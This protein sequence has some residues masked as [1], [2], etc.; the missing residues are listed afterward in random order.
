MVLKNV[1]LIDIEFIKS[2]GFFPRKKISPLL[3]NHVEKSVKDLK[4][5]IKKFH[6]SVGICIGSIPFY[7]KRFDMIDFTTRAV[8]K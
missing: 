2:Y 8:A 7:L 3:R 5:I 4:L 1:Q 6:I